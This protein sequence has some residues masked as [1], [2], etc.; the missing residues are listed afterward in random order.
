MADFRDPWSAIDYVDELKQTAYSRRKNLSLEKK[1]LTSADLTLVVSEGMVDSFRELG[2]GNVVSITNGFDSE[3][4][5]SEDIKSSEFFS[6]AHVGVMP[7][8]RN[9]ETLWKALSKLSEEPEFKSDLEIRLIGNVDDSVTQSIKDS[10]LSENVNYIGQV[11]H[12]EAVREMRSAKALL[13]VINRSVNAK[14]ILTGKLFE[15]MGAHRPILVIGPRDGE[16]NQVI[17]NAGCGEVVDYD[18]LP[19]MIQVIRKWHQRFRMGDLS[20]SDEKIDA[21]S[22]RSLTSNLS[23]LLD[24]L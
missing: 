22:R 20:V 6:I 5:E 15:Y 2:A 18:D 19:G 3:D 4:F 16:I 17:D 11:S 24:S 9:P 14:S 10:G 13:L 21:F 8:S 23:S 7:P 12:K 1:V